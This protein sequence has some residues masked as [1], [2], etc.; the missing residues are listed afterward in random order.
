MKKF[1]VHVWE[2]ATWYKIIEAE[3]KEQAEAKAHEDI[4]ENGYDDW[5]IGNHGTSDI[6]EVEELWP[7]NYIGTEFQIYGQFIIV[8]QMTWC[9]RPCGKES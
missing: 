3:T 8:L 5:E 9:I 2:E 6:S 1:K 7:K 4:S